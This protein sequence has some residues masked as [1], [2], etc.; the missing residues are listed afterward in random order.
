MGNNIDYW[1]WSFVGGMVLTIVFLVAGHQY[2]TLLLER[3][4][5]LPIPESYT[6]LYISDPQSLPT[7][8]ISGQAPSF[9]FTLVNHEGEK[10]EYAYQVYFIA[11]GTPKVSSTLL[12]TA[13]VSIP[14]GTSLMREIPITIESQFSLD[15]KIFVVLLGRNQELHFNVHIDPAPQTPKRTKRP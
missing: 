2:I 13:T 4:R 12:T 9:S 3:Y 5:I 1:K 6:E 15:G 14:A 7:R 10:R 11:S 8:I